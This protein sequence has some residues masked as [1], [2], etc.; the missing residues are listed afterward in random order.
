MLKKKKPTELV[1]FAQ[2]TEVSN[3]AAENGNSANV[4]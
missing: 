3:R 2:P 1:G 4:F